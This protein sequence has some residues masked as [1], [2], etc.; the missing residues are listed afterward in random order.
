MSGTSPA[1]PIAE[2]SIAGQTSSER[3]AGA[4]SRADE[5]TAR[6]ELRASVGDRSEP[7]ALLHR[8]ASAAEFGPRR[9]QEG[10]GRRAIP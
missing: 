10:D 2:R 5:T 7:A 6:D 3:K 9:A 4:A 1:E 8:L